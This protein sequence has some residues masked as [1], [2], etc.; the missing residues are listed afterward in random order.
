VQFHQI[1]SGFAGVNHRLAEVVNNPGDL[2]GFQRAWR[3]GIDASRVALF[4]TQRGAG[5]RTDRRRR[6]RRFTARLQAGVGNTASVPQLDRNTA[7]AFVNWAEIW[8]ASLMIRPEL[9]R[10][11]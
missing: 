6:D 7:I 4:I 10:W 8:V 11:R 2:F 1:E 9:A 3:R 5:F